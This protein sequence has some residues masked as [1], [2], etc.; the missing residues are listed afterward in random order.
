MAP[1]IVHYQWVEIQPAAPITQTSSIEFN[2][3][4]GRHFMIDMI[5]CFVS[6]F[7]VFTFT[8]CQNCANS[9]CL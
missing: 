9:F 5:L 6:M 4:N 7:K 2:I 1:N 8:A 3:P